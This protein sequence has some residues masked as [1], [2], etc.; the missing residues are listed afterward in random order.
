MP[1]L[2]DVPNTTVS[3]YKFLIMTCLLA[4]DSNSAISSQHSLHTARTSCLRFPLSVP[5]TSATSSLGHYVP[6]TTTSHLQRHRSLERRS[7]LGREPV[8]IL[9]VID[10]HWDVI[11]LRNPDKP[12]ALYKPVHTDTHKPITDLTPMPEQVSTKHLYTYKLVVA[13]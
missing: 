12:V 10:V 5:I 13:W 4:E 1:L 11:H 2:L 6:R 8:L 9:I 7:Y 3:R